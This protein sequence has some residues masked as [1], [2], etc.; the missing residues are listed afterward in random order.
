MQ[1]H[2]P[3]TKRKVREKSVALL[4]S[5][6]LN[7]I[8]WMTTWY[9]LFHNV[10]LIIH[11][12]RHPIDIG[13]TIPI[14]C[15]ILDVLIYHSIAIRIKYR[16]KSLNSR[17][18]LRIRKKLRIPSMRKRGGQ[19]LVKSMIY[20]TQSG[21][22]LCRPILQD[23]SRVMSFLQAFID[24]PSEIYPPRFLIDNVRYFLRIR[25]RYLNWVISNDF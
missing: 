23:L 9:K 12:D 16:Y 5:K 18:L 4:A 21:R 24:L 1:P 14:I 19:L 10:L 17:Y 20:T 8:F 25:R 7:V 3:D 15:N 2:A 13:M 22:L 6:C 11:V